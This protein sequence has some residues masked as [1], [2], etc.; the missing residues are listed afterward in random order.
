MSHRPYRIYLKTLGSI[1]LPVFLFGL[2][3]QVTL[4]ESQQEVQINF[5][6]KNVEQAEQIF[7]SIGTNPIHL[8][9][10]VYKAKVSADVYQQLQHDPNFSY[11]EMD[12]PVSAATIIT[13]DPFFTTD[14]T[15]EEQQWY[16][17]RTQVQDAWDFSKGSSTV[18]VAIIDTGV[19]ASH[20]EL[21]DG[22]IVE[23][24]N[25]ITNKPILANFDSDDNGHGTAVAG[26]IGAIPNNQKG[27]AGIN[28]NI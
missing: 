28:W 12:Q 24:Y 4:G 17:P 5:E 21:N 2:F 3:P 11:V 9:Q 7:Q 20:L 14:F 18:T 6:V 27:I 26:V 19:H 22:R 23:G 15:A 1:F 25:T 16:L 13:S 8:F 10:N